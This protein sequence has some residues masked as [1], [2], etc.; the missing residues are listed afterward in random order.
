MSEYNTK[1][2]DYGDYLHVQ[3][4]DR[5]IKRVDFPEEVQKEITKKDNETIIND[6]KIDDNEKREHCIKSSLNRSKNNLYYIARSN[7][8]DYFL[9]FTFDRKKV[10]SSDFEA[11]SKKITNFMNNLR[12][13]SPDLKYLIVPEL[14]K[15]MIHYHFHGLIAN[16]DGLKLTDSGKVDF[17]GNKIYNIDGWRDRKGESLGFTTATKIKD[18]SAVRNYIGKYISK[19][20]MQRLKYKKRYFASQNV[21]LCPETYHMF[22][23]DDI[24]SMFGDDITYVKTVSIDKINRIKYFEVKKS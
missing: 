11:C 8:W 19:E 6:I 13:K 12:K 17:S 24:Y 18:Q 4:Y 21:N 20:L 7:K 15:D 9:T 1:V 3:F 16:A 10:D 2:I 23:L 14:H 22:S 5:T